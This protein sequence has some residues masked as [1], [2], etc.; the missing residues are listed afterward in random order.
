MEGAAT[1]VAARVDTIEGDYLTSTAYD[2]LDGRLTAVE[3]AYLTTG[4]LV[5]YATESWV[6]AGY[7]SVTGGV[8]LL[9]TDTTYTVSTPAELD[10]TLDTVDG[11]RI[12]RD[13]T[14]TIQFTAGTYA[15]SDALEIRHPDGASIHLVG[16]ETYPGQVVLQFAGTDGVVVQEGQVAE[17]GTH[18]ELMETRGIYWKLSTIQKN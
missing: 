11:Y 13:T 16:D 12:G 10:A 7:G 18:Q 2:D 9:D 4:D 1:A 6:E 15:F 14:V 3:S 8:R 5:G 17:R